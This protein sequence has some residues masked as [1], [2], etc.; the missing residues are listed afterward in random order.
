MRARTMTAVLHV[1]TNEPRHD[2]VIVHA[3]LPA[4]LAMYESSVRSR[5]RFLAPQQPSPRVEVAGGFERI[6]SDPADMPSPPP[7][8]TEAP[9]SA[10]ACAI[11]HQN[12]EALRIHPT[13]QLTAS[14]AT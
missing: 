7:A 6:G 14:N 13:R 1:V 11:L 9:T 4:L 8:A 3:L 5:T 2:A 12:P 10:V